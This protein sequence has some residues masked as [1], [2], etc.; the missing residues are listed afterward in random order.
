M[1]VLV[2]RLEGPL[3]AW[4]A[5]GK[6][7]IR[8]TEREPTKS[9]VIGL[10]G[11]ALGMERSDDVTLSGLASLKMG[12]RVDRAGT[13]LRDYHTAGGGTFRGERRY[14]VHDTKACVPS[15]RY[16]LQDASFV[17]ALAGDDALVLRIA[18]ALES[19]RYALF[20][21]RR[22]CPPSVPVLV[23]VVE[24]T[25]REAL[26]SAPLAADPDNEPYRIVLE[27][28]GGEGDIRDDVPLSFAQ[29]E[30]RYGRRYVTS[31]WVQ[32]PAEVAS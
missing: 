9:G 5:Q 29:I 27:S 31:E 25:I 12:V 14:F 20:L 18:T 11:A 23:N 22:S 28:A 3:Q 13:L 32:A 2:L 7:V 1:K 21:G 4:S 10:L 17:A 8:D 26:A 19:P 15:E 6:L 30:R 16:Y 24:G